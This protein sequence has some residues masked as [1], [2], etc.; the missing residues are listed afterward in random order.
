LTC[1]FVDS[2]GADTPYPDITTVGVYF[3]RFGE[4]QT[5]D[6]KEYLQPREEYQGVTDRRKAV[7]SE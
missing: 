6:V 4:L 5:I 2:S 3:A 7:G 1:F